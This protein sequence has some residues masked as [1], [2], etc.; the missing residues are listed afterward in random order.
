MLP[1]EKHPIG[2]AYSDI[3]ILFAK[4]DIFVQKS[5]K[6]LLTKVVFSKIL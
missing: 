2:R 3:S 4:I 5:Q 6:L 1:T